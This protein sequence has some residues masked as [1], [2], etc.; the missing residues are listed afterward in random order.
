MVGVT[1]ALAVSSA[2]LERPVAAAL[3]WGWTTA[4]SIAVGLYCRLSARL[5]PFGCRRQRE[6]GRFF[7]AG[8]V[9][10]R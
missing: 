1:I 2:H 4:A 7:M 10:V 3:Y 5:V 6:D 9:G 8:S